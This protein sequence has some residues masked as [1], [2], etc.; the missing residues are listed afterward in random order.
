MNIYIT[1]QYMHL[2]KVDFVDM[3]GYKLPRQYEAVPN[4]VTP[5][6]RMTLFS[7]LDQAEWSSFLGCRLIF[8]L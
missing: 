3:H 8:R 2:Y 1:K 7:A 6:S 5:F 4:K